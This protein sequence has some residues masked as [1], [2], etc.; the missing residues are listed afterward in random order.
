MARYFSLQTS[1][2]PKT[3]VAALLADLLGKGLAKAVL[4]PARQSAGP[5][6]KQT[7]ISDPKRLD[8]VDLFAP[9]VWSSTARVVSKLT[10]D[11]ARET[12]AVVLRSC[13][14]RGLIELS[15]LNQGSTDTLLLIGVDCLGRLENMDYLA[16]AQAQ[17]EAESHVPTD[18]IV[19]T[20]R[21]C[22]LPVAPCVDI[23]LC[24]IGGEPE[25]ALVFEAVT[26][27]GA[28]A[29]EQLALTELEGAPPGRDE[30]V[31]ALVQ[32]RSRFREALFAEFVEQTRDVAGLKAAVAACNNCYNCRVACPVCY[33]RECVFN[34]DTF[35]HD[36]ERYLAWADKR[37]QLE[38]PTDTVFYHLTRMLHVGALCVGCGQCTS[39]CPND[40]PVAQL[41]ITAAAKVQER[42][43]YTPGLDPDQPQPL[44]VFEDDELVEL[45]G[46]RK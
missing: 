2:Q 43:G 33:C 20:C 13:E 35:R 29:L 28:A 7:L 6:V 18:D 3:A 5:V 46:Q 21:A 40:I 25:R 19:P 4:A 9:V 45:T 39:A 14:V 34:T 12:I 24:T 23:R 10:S 27:K 31:E 22:E 15:K 36:G 16:L 41:L 32:E 17:P 8:H 1:G 30:A 26:D 37:G 11:P 38:M 44:A 42:F